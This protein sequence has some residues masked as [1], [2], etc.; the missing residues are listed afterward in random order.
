M[1]VILMGTASDCWGWSPSSLDRS[2]G[3]NCERP[4]ACLPAGLARPAPPAPRQLLAPAAPHGASCGGAGRRAWPDLCATADAGSLRTAPHSTPIPELPLAPRT[5][6]PRPAPAQIHA[7]FIL[8]WQASGLG[9]QVMGALCDILTT[10]PPPPDGRPWRLI[11]TGH[12]LGGALASL[13]AYEAASLCRQLP[14]GGCRAD[15]Q[16]GG[17]GRRGGLVGL[18]ACSAWCCGRKMPCLEGTHPHPVPHFSVLCQVY[19]F[20]APR[21][22]NAAFARQYAARVPAS[23][24]VVHT[25]DTIVRNGGRGS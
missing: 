8:T 4:F 10:A 17:A 21:P 5:L 16:V 25:D 18:S 13:A 11:F 1:C 9:G 14:G 23:F 12:S 3:A 2:Q 20:G 24:D 6:P 7:G 19:T 22:G 15:I